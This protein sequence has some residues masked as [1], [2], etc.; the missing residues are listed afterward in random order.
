MRQ[1]EAT[2]TSLKKQRNI[3]NFGLKANALTSRSIV[4]AKEGENM[5]KTKS[6]IIALV[7][8]LSLVFW[9]G[10]ALAQGG[11]STF[12]QQYPQGV[13]GTNY[14]P[15]GE[16]PEA[17]SVGYHPTGWD[18]FEASWLIGHRV[19]SPLQGEL[20]QIEDLMIDS[21]N[22][23]IALVVLSGVQGFGAKYVAAPF[24]ALERTGE[25]TYQLNF[26]DQ[27]ASV[28]WGNYNYRDPY[29]DDL[30]E[31]R[32][33]VGLSRIPST[34]NPLW[35]DSVYQ[36][37][38]KTPYWTEGRTPYPDILSYRTVGPSIL[39]SLILGNSG[40]VL[41][42]ATVQS[43]D[44]EMTP[45]IDDLVI[46]SKDGRVAFLVVDRVPGR[47][48]QVAVPFSELSMS[49]NVFSLNTTGERLAAAPGFDESADMGNREYATSVFRFFG[50]QPY[51]TEE[52]VR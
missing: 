48:E 34:I 35:A 8:T 7:S 23:R 44:G 19:Y 49:G 25:D 36:Y 51:W 18:T 12:E 52:E 14:H 42:G 6:L 47:A 32:S 21:A 20:G 38:G 1:E 13:V 10:S 41:M 11:M 29:A 3:I 4:E 16:F 2:L 45:R 30:Y 31:W 22:G 46:D 43:T 40:P 33:I 27:Y 50:V 5:N 24:G 15:T 37:F 26:R 39:Q 9:G 17:S 28:S